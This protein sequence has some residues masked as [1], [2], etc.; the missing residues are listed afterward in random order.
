MP[1]YKIEVG[2]FFTT[3]QFVCKTPGS[4]PTG[5][6]RES[7]DHHF[8]GGT[9]YNDTPYSLVWFE[10]QLSL[11]SNETVIGKSRFEQWI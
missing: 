3:I 8:Q 7:S 9:I 10:N 2:D 5:H 11:G 6:W 1:H 4:L